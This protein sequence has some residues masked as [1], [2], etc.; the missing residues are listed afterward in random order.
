MRRAI[1]ICVLSIHVD[2]DTIFALRGWY[3]RTSGKLTVL[4][5]NNEILYQ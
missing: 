3:E 1:Y 2:V 5:V 4:N